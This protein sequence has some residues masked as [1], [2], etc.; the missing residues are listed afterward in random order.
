M[1][2]IHNDQIKNGRLIRQYRWIEYLGKGSFGIVCKFE[3]VQ[4][5]DIYAIKIIELP[6]KFIIFISNQVYIFVLLNSL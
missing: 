6:G 2:L 1:S 5:K 3:Y 4:S